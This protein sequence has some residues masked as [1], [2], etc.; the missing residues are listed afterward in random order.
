MQLV[1]PK[2][3]H[4]DKPSNTY[5]TQYKPS[6]CL[7]LIWDYSPWSKHGTAWRSKHSYEF[8]LTL[9]F[10]ATR[11]QQ[12]LI[13]GRIWKASLWGEKTSTI[14]INFAQLIVNLASVVRPR[15]GSSSFFSNECRHVFAN[16]IILC[17]TLLFE[18]FRFEGKII[19]LN[20]A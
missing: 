17:Q 9:A 6:T 7:F 10:S 4:H 3:V 2:Y 5:I 16:F 19:E 15:K 11:P 20:F 14:R 13:R 1:S 8:F 12:E 18:Y